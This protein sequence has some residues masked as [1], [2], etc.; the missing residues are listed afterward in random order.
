MI[1]LSKTMV[2]ILM[3]IFHGSINGTETE[4]EGI[5]S[6]S[7]DVTLEEKGTQQVATSLQD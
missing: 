3:V 7:Q 2:I 6:C 4:A 1:I 5:K